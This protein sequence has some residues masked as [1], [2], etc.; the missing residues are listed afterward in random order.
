MASVDNVYHELLRDI[1]DNGNFN[2]D[3]TGTGTIKVFGRMIR[4]GL[5]SNEFPLLT[6]KK[7]HTR[8]I[9]EELLWFLSGDTNAATLSRKGVNIWNGD[10][11]KYYENH[12]TDLPLLTK[13]EFKEKLDNDMAFASEWGEL[14]PIYGAQWTNWNNS[15]NQIQQVIDDLKNNPASRR[16]MVNAWNVDKIPSMKL[17]PC[18]YGFQLDVEP[19]SNGKPILNLMWNQ[20]SIDVGL[21]LPFNIASYGFLLLMFADQVDMIPGNLIGSLGN[22]HIYKNHL[23]MVI[24]QLQRNPDKY[25][26]PEVYL[27]Y[28]KKPE[29]I[30][31][32]KLEHFQIDNYQSY[33]TIKMPLSN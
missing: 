33:P 17:P 32:Y 4:F 6:T 25:Q 30:F 16:I 23:P 21:G 15:I 5:T 2:D 1:L 12:S 24:E 8:G 28:D 18:H 29:S 3:R 20:R 7:L 22:V 26:G 13:G 10:A 19:N 11:Y 31:D 27:S 14:G 9:I